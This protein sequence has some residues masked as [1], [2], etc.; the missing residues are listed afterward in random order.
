MK[1]EGG[2]RKQVDTGPWRRQ[3]GGSSS[4]KEYMESQMDA[5]DLTTQLHNTVGGLVE[6]I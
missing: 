6:Y 1:M 2:R 5:D 4:K 3:G